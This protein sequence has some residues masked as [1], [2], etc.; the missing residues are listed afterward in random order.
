MR[1]PGDLDP[2]TKE[3]QG[4]GQT[5]TSVPVSPHWMTCDDGKAITK[6]LW[7]ASQQNGGK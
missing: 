4:W 6:L 7:T 5:N 1:I 3:S 2:S